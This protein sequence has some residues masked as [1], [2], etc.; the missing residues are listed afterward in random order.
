MAAD[1]VDRLALWT[2]PVI[3]RGH[4]EQTVLAILD[5]VYQISGSKDC[6]HMLI[7]DHVVPN[8]VFFRRDRILQLCVEDRMKEL[9]VHLRLFIL[10]ISNRLNKLMPPMYEGFERR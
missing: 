8:K 7:G 5:A 4:L 3:R 2:L 6:P 1:A 10:L 9:E